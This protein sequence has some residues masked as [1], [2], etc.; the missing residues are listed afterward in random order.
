VLSAFDGTLK[1][2]SFLPMGDDVYAQAPYQQVS[3]E[4]WEAL[5][6]NVKP[7]D[8]DRLYSPS[9]GMSEASG[10][11]Y[12]STDACEVRAVRS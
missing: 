1:S 12:C 10:E 8:W 5:R 9:A 6:A 11:L 2:L 7:I 3:R 4:V